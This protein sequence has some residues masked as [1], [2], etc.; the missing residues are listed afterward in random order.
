M[1][2]VQNLFARE[3]TTSSAAVEA[4]RSVLSLPEAEIDYARAKVALDAIVDPGIDKDATLDELDHMAD[5][6]LRMAGPSPTEAD[7][8]NALRVLI[9]RAGPWNG[10]RPFDYDHANFKDIRL[11]LIAHYLETRRGNCVSMPI[12]F[13]ILADKLGIQMS[14]AFAPSHFFLRH[15]DRQGRITNLEATSGA[16]PARDLWIRESRGV[17]DRAVASGFQMRALSRREGVAAMAHT[18]VE[19]MMESA[20]YRETLAL[21][22]LIIRC[23]PRDGMAWANHAQACFHILGTEFLRPFGSALSIPIPRRAEYLLLLQRNHA[24]FATAERLGFEGT[25]ITRNGRTSAC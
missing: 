14:L 9:Y 13:L 5:R 20:R 19:A 8:L 25:P 18:V 10:N 17:T 4:V 15:R 21:T 24:A 1:A 3:P 22:D 6:A 2:A 12:L 16:D 11:K 7:L 23:N